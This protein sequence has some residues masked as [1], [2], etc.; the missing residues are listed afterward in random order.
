LAAQE[1]YLAAGLPPADLRG[2]HSQRHR[3]SCRSGRRL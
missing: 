2:I 3:A 1:K